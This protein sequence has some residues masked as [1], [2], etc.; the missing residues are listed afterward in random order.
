MQTKITQKQ[1]I[2]TTAIILTLC[3]IWG[4][5]LLPASIS[6]AISGWLKA[7]I[8]SILSGLSST[9]VSTGDG[10]LRKIAHAT[11]YAA[12]GAELFYLFS[13]IMKKP[14][15][16]VILSGFSVAL[17]DETIQL[18]VDGRAGLVVDIWID[19]FGVLVGIL[20]LAMIFCIKE[21]FNIHKANSIY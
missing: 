10:L 5:S 7:F 18:F 19:I 12:L 14:L 8:M 9:S 6:G 17:I 11:E 16:S 4:N 20:L 1:N 3:F 15:S 21:T 13:I 2:L